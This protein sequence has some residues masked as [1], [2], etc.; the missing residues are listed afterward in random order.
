MF[1]LALATGGLHAGISSLADPLFKG[2]HMT[3]AVSAH[4]QLQHISDV[5]FGF[6]TFVKTIFCLQSL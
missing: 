6:K 1:P 3:G 2:G 4:H 5:S